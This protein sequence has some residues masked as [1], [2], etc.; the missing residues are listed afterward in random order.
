M[1]NIESILPA[2]DIRPPTGPN[3]E[4][5]KRNVRALTG[6]PTDPANPADQA[7]KARRLREVSKDFEAAL[8]NIVMKEMQKTVDESGFV[9]DSA[10][11]Q[12]RGMFWQFL[13]DTVADQGG[14]GIADNLYKDFCRMAKIDPA[15]A[16][17]TPKLEVLR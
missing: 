4:A 7:D 1:S 13:S 12:I 15:S 14:A 16:E 2:G 6:K 9:D 5:M 3:I 11:K 17:D 8:L 10:S